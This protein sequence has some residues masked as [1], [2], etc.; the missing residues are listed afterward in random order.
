MRGD[1]LPRLLLSAGPRAKKEE[2]PR[3]AIDFR[4]VFQ[5]KTTTSQCKPYASVNSKSQEYSARL[6]RRFV[7]SGTV[8]AM[9]VVADGQAA[10]A[11]GQ[12][13]EG[14][15]GRVVAIEVTIVGPVKAA[16]VAGLPKEATE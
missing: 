5:K 8:S 16:W 2:L 7:C 3:F 10:K 12:E 6:S 4:I 1:D 11:G 13:G 14:I 9:R 15:C